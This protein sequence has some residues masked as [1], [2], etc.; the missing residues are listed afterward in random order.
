MTQNV[1]ATWL[2]I[3]IYVRYHRCHQEEELHA[4]DHA[5]VVH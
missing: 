5:I 4:V 2:R 3:Y 1:L